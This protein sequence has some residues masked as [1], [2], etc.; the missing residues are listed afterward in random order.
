MAKPSAKDIWLGLAFAGLVACVVA[1]ER[2]AAANAASIT[3]EVA[4]AVN[5]A[6]NDDAR[7]VTPSLTL[8]WTVTMGLGALFGL[9]STLSLVGLARHALDAHRVQR[10]AQAARVVQA[11]S[12]AYPALAVQAEDDAGSVRVAEEQRDR[13]TLARLRVFCV[14]AI[15]VWLGWQVCAM[16][17]DTGSPWPGGLHIAAIVIAVAALASA[18]STLGDPRVGWRHAAVIRIQ[19]LVLLALFAVVFLVPLTAGQVTDVLRAWGDGP[20]SRAAAGIAAALLLGAVVR[21]SATRILLLSGDSGFW[22]PPSEG[23]RAPWEVGIFCV[24]L[25][26]GAVACALDLELGGGVLILFAFIGAA[27]RWAT[28]A[29]D[30]LLSHGSRLTRLPDSLGVVPLTIVFAGLVA[31]SVDSIVLPAKLSVNDQNLLAITAAVGVLLAILAGLSRR[32]ASAPQP[33]PAASLWKRALAPTIGLVGL[34]AALVLGAV[35]DVTVPDVAAIVAL[36]AGACALAYPGIDVHI[37]GAPQFWGAGGVALGIAVA[38]YLEPLAAP[39]A[40]GTLAVVFAGATAALLA[41]HLAGSV[42][43]RRALLAPPQARGR[44]RAIARWAH[45]LLPDRVPLL[46]I[47]VAWIFAGAFFADDNVHQARTITAAKD[48]APQPLQDEVNAWLEDAWTPA[49]TSNPDAPYMPMLLVAASGGGSKAAYW[50]DLVLDCLFGKG[51]P[52]GETGARPV[53]VSKRASSRT[54]PS[55][56]AGRECK[57]ARTGPQRYGKLFLTSSVS[58]GSV[59][60][61]HFVRNGIPITGKERPWVDATTGPE[62]LSPI[63]AWGLF[64]DLPVSMLGANTDPR[65]C[66]SDWSCR[67]NADRALIQEAAVAR[68]PDGIVPPPGGGLLEPGSNASEVRKPLMIFNGAMD[69]ADGRVLLSRAQLAP[70][71]LSDPGC[72]TPPTGEPAAGSI[73]A[74]DLLNPQKLR[75]HSVAGRRVYAPARPPISDV[76]L[77]TAA[78]L[79]ARFPFVEPP[80]RLGEREQPKP[81]K[82]SP[83]PHSEGTLPAQWI[84]DGGYVEN[85]GVLTIVDLLPKLTQIVDAW[86]TKHR[87]A[88]VQFIVVSI[89]DDP[90]VSDSDVARLEDR[91]TALGIGKQVGKG[92]LTRLAR[93]RLESCQYRDVTYRR[94]SPNPHAGAT[95]ATGWEISETARTQDLGQAIRDRKPMLKEL[96]RILKGKAESR[97]CADPPE[98]EPKSKAP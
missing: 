70:P 76:P 43:D 7:G 72:R 60:I 52:L 55:Q 19:L 12:V 21:A 39:R 34:A 5:D 54:K 15:V 26:V 87:A 82:P 38:V 44:V 79:S 88:H 80:G 37:P 63:A 46:T 75:E 25:I 97:T 35:Q 95:A 57:P 33:A 78:L 92:Y 29:H 31:A 59:G 74:H 90:E 86:K 42:G 22:P 89:D 48:A 24:A 93:D 9:A 4:G 32:Q 69:G 62:V 20:F 47:V 23:A 71:R 6:V 83:C 50:T 56:A 30:D 11:M 94:L 17:T 18:S 73:D 27:T 36:L 16:Q 13:R 10:D 84:R 41:L 14:L 96:R 98:P 61:H 77:I 1:A 40:F 67:V 64:H 91:N 85:S 66:R 81:G 2:F 58:G 51:M 49:Y 28:P 45:R 65:K 53:D 8:L 68:F 3:F